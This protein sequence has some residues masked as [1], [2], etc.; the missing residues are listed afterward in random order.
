[1]VCVQFSHSCVHLWDR[2]GVGGAANGPKVCHWPGLLL[3]KSL[4]LGFTQLGTA[5]TGSARPEC[6]GGRA[7]HDREVHIALRGPRPVR[8]LHT[9]VRNARPS[10]YNTSLT[11]QFL[12][13][14]SRSREWAHPSR[15]SGLQLDGGRRLL[16]RGRWLDQ[17][18][19]RGRRSCAKAG[20]RGRGRAHLGMRIGR[21]RRL[22]WMLPCLTT[23]S[24]TAVFF[25]TC[26]LLL[27]KAV[28]LCLL[29]LFA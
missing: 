17:C 27:L 29:C 14:V 6:D 19:G 4:D 16:L 7:H 15:E 20:R 28:V 8:R 13:Q 23:T 5:G 26:L 18:Q 12:W 25:G 9:R 24:S 22:P 2:G 11:G 21:C 10:P 3:K 1:M